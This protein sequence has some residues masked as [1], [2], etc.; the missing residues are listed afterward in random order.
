M[1]GK[2]LSTGQKLNF[3]NKLIANA[4]RKGDNHSLNF[5]K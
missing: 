5:V 1:S 3:N 2:N 4:V